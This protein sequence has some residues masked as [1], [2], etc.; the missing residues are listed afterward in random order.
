MP[1]TAAFGTWKSPITVE[2]LVS[3]A[4]GISEV[5]PAADAVWWAESRPDEGGRTA[6]MRWGHDQIIE[7]TPADANVRTTVHE[8]GGGAWWVDDEVLYYVDYSDQRLRRLLVG[9][10]PILLSPEAPVNGARRYADFR[11][12]ANKHWLIAVGESHGDGL[13]EPENYIEAIATDGSMRTQVLC[14]GNDFYGSPR[15]S[16]DGSQLAW[17]QWRHPNMPWDDT[18]LMVADLD[19]STELASLSNERFVAG[20]EG[21]AIVQPE[22]SPNNHLHYLSDCADTWQLYRQGQDAPL[23]R[24]E[25]EIGY[26]P[27]VFGLSRYAFK[28]NGDIVAARFDKGVEFL[29]GYPA[30]SAFNA[31][32]THGDKVAFAAFAWDAEVAIVYDGAVVRA[33]R[34]LNLH[35]AL[36]M[37][38]ES[39]RFPTSNNEVA[40]ALFYEPANPDYSAPENEKPPLIVL[41]HGGPTSAAR[42]QLSLARQFWTS[43]GFAVVDVNYRGSSGFGRR[44]RKKLD[45]QWGIA[46]VDDCVAVANYLVERGDVDAKRLIIR[47]GSAGGFTV[48]SALAFH[49]V[50]TAGANMYGVADLETL[51]GDTH[52]FESRYLDNLIGP[53]PKDKAIYDAR[54]PIKHLDGFSVPMIVLQGSED[55][56]VPPNQSRMIVDALDK[57]GVPVAYIEYEG[58][59]HGF[60]KASTIKHALT[61]E[62]SFYGK[63]FDFQPA[64]DVADIEI[65][66]LPV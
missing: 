41:A 59:Q 38:A 24:V 1:E 60:R 64:D 25:G 26:P 2:M 43:R 54:S 23:H 11:C 28:S 19:S 44:Y 56:I 13:A 51:A 37:K 63:V 46:D 31:I 58:E 30:Y 49:Q 40:Y 55:A 27:W 42:S 50:F 9:E 4:V 5:V 10:S 33:P 8:Y 52:K 29:D 45:G 7:V 39:L 65:R 15:V 6:I 66:N 32:R 62:L 3:G 57:R 17:V 53:F 16:P 18:E 14:R 35:S 12:T 34:Q 36:M 20:G 22:W 48:L 47:G 61:A 21:V